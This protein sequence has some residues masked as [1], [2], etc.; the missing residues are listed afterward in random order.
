MG[1]KKKQ[2][3]FWEDNCMEGLILI[4]FKATYAIRIESLSSVSVCL[5]FICIS[6]RWD[7]PVFKYA[8]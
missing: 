8:E 3:E 1:G 6:I 7:K 5:M 4:L 2:I